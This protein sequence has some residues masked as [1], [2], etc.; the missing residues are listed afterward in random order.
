MIAPS[1]TPNSVS[2]TPEPQTTS[3]VT[4]VAAALDCSQSRSG[5][6]FPGR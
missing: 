1:R 2:H 5:S 3:R 6:S 4:N